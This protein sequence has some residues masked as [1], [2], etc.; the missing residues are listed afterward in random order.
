[1]WEQ[2]CVP[3]WPDDLKSACGPAGT[4]VAN[5]GS[6]NNNIIDIKKKQQNMSVKYITNRSI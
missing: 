1:M 2:L 6:L 4:Y 5:V 3:N